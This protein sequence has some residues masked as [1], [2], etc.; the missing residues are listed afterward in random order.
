MTTPGETLATESERFASFGW[1]RGTS[2]NLSAVVS[3]DP[4]RLAVTASGL[5]KGSLTGSDVVVVNE[6]GAA[7]DDSG[8]RPSAEAALHARIARLTGAGA[9]VHVHTVEAVVAGRR[10]PTGIKLEGLEMLKGIGVAAEGEQVTLPVIANSQDMGVLG[11]RLEA[12]RDPQVPAVVVAG[13][14]LYAWGADPMRA[15]HHTEVVQWLLEFSVRL[16]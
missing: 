12:A 8:R 13:H 14:G 3:R 5:D 11:D 7:V 4:L 16:G 1:M 10:W 9:V 2:G 15:R 6:D